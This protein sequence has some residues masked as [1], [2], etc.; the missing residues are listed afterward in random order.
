[1]EDKK[2]EQR[3]NEL[4]L[5]IKDLVTRLEKIEGAY[6]GGVVLDGAPNYVRELAA[7]GDD[8]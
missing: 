3:I 1:M 8:K 4:E 7:Q 2:F 5:I 6:H